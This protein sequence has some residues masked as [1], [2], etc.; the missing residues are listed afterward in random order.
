VSEPF[1]VS[2]LD[3]VK[4]MPDVEGT[5]WLQVRRHFGIEGFGVNAYRGDA[6]AQVIE[7]HDELGDTA[8]RHEELYVVVRG[9]ARF[10]VDGDEV[11][12]PSGTVV[13]VGPETR[14]GAIAE[15]DGTTV[16]VI[17][18]EPGEAFKVSMWEASSDA[19]TAYREKD[20][21]AAVT[22]FERV[23]AEYPR[24][25]IVLYNLA[26]CEA[27]VGRGD[28]AV[29]HLDEAIQREERFR[30]LAMSDED[31]ASIRDRA[32]FPA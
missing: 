16:L 10:T 5:T 2:S 11:P 18:G 22:G 14:R 8:S 9:R 4:A 29:E 25:A 15:E 31:F 27:L 26:C 13:H 32:D 12:G 7:E 24:T 30:E 21:E 6:G 19:W 3:D 28:E 1:V 23:L 20:Y 17:G